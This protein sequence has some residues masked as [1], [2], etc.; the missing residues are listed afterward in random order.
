LTADTAPIPE[1]SPGQ[2]DQ[3]RAQLGLSRHRPRRML[4]AAAVVVLV[5]GAAAG[6]WAVG[7]AHPRT[8]TRTVTRTVVHTRTVHRT[9]TSTATDPGLL[10]CAQALMGAWETD[11]QY[12]DAGQLPPSAA[13]GYNPDV[14]ACEAYP[15]VWNIPPD[16]SP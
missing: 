16:Q 14:S 2:V 1:L 12:A 10:R 9:I 3:L 8:I 7:H 6:G 11:G 15:A 5:L 4:V 13:Q